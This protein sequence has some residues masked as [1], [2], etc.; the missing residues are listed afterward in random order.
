ME[1]GHSSESSA[2]TTHLEE[3][4]Y[5][6]LTLSEFFLRNLGHRTTGDA[7]ISVTFMEISRLIA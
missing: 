5:V 2:E 6:A 1:Q 3:V 4:H 7:I